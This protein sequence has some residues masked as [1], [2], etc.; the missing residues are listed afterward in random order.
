MARAVRSK[1]RPLALTD[2]KIGPGFWAKRCAANR[3]ATIPHIYRM[4]DDTG[5]IEALKLEWRPG[6]SRRPHPFYDSDVAKWL[7]A[8]SYSLATHPDPALRKQVD[9]V[10]ALLRRAQQSDGYLN[11]HVTQVDPERRWTN[12]RDMHE[13]YCAGHLMEAGAAHFQAT[14]DRSL[15]GVV[16]RYADYIDSVFGP[17]G[18]RG[19]PGHEEIELALVKLYRATGNQRYLTLAGHFVDARGE[20]PAFFDAEARA[21]GEDARAGRRPN[22]YYQAHEPVRRQRVVVGH[23]VRAMYLYSAMAD[24]AGETNDADL[25][26]A[27]ERLWNN[28]TQ[29]RMYITGGVGPTA[30]NEGFNGDYNLPND[31]AYAETCAAVGV[32]LWAQ[33]MLNLSADARYADVME[34]ALY[35]SVLSGISLDGRKFFYENPLAQYPAVTASRHGGPGRQEFFVCACCPPNVARL[36]A[37]IGGYA[38][39]VGPKAVFVHLY[40]A[41]RATAEIA[42]RQITLTQQTDYPWGGQVRLTVKTD[43]AARFKLNLRIPSWC[44]KH[45]IK[46]NNSTVRAK[47]VK[48]YAAVSREWNDG[49]VVALALAMPVERVEANPRVPHN[50]GKV[51]IQ[52]GP[53]VYCLEDA[54]NAA[55]VHTILLPERARLSARF[56]A[57]LLGGVT[58][59]EGRAVALSP[60]RWGARLYRSAAKAATRPVRIRA[61]PYCFWAN[62]RQG[63][64]TVWLP[65]M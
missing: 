21:R 8:A 43:R 3:R 4:L 49:D 30:A 13:L 60:A 46:V 62:R 17:G 64:M 12:L 56:E 16:C 18:R 48:G 63:A 44:R 6:W 9:E 33:R 28:L 37:S 20:P 65:R 29:R 24:L 47:A 32:V 58:V 41:G 50:V 22:E 2:V 45:T 51:A 34:R 57:R 31:T 19:Y 35:N 26:G 11:S 23:A 39:S 52:R 27:C 14:G 15:L 42:G 1:L 54:D 38:Y 40:V 25:L 36:I 5:R 7:E 53:I 10:I 55:A 61:I 59:V